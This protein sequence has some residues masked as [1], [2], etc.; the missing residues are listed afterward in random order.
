M[1]N[2]IFL[3]NEAICKVSINW[4]LFLKYL[5]LFVAW[6]LI[7]LIIVVYVTKVFREPI[8]F[9]LRNL[10]VKYGDATISSNQPLEKNKNVELKQEQKKPKDGP[11]QYIESVST[12]DSEELKKLILLWRE[13]AYIWE[14]KYLNFFFVANTKNVLYWLYGTSSA[15]LGTYHNIFSEKIPDVS[16]RS[17]ILTALENHFLIQITGASI[18]EVTPKG[19]EYAEVMLV[20]RMSEN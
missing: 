8:S 18:V 2:F 12:T 13:N 4:E 20:P 3:E 1:F 19:K 7:T 10:T 9:W 5:S 14:Y 11:T 16:E 17:A 15:S 6:P